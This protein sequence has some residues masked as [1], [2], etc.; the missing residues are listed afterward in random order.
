MET[1][2]DLS[3]DFIKDAKKKNSAF[4]AIKLPTTEAK[5]Q[6]LKDSGTNPNNNHF[7][8]CN[9]CDHG[10]LDLPLMNN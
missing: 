4:Q 6:Y 1:F 9:N 10:L 3:E 2:Q 7:S 5:H 8:M